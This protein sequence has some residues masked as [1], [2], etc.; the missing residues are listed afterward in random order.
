MSSAIMAKKTT[1]AKAATNTKHSFSELLCRDPK[2]SALR[3][4]YAQEPPAKRRAVS[5]WAYDESIANSLVGVAFA[6]LKGE[7]LPA[8]RW[9]LPPLCCR[10]AVMNMAAVASRKA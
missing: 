7:Q 9:R 4:E 1:T 3:A 5:E 8:P 2:L 6:C 10:L